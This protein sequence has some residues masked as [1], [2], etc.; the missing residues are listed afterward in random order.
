MLNVVKANFDN[1]NSLGVGRYIDLYQSTQCSPKYFAT[2]I[3]SMS[4][5]THFMTVNDCLILLRAKVIYNFM[6]YGLTRPIHKDGD[7]DVELATLK[8]LIDLGINLRLTEEECKYLN[9]KFSDMKELPMDAFYVYDCQELGSCVGKKYANIR[10]DRNAL[11][12]F[13]SNGYIDEFWYSKDKPIPTEVFCDTM[14]LVSFEQK[15]IGG[16]Y[17]VKGLDSVV[18]LLKGGNR[19][20]HTMLLFCEGKVIAFSANEVYG[21]NAVNCHNVTDHSFDKMRSFGSG[22]FVRAA[23]YLSELGVKRFNFGSCNND[24]GLEF[25]K[26]RH[27]PKYVISNRTFNLDKKITYDKFKLLL[28]KENK[29]QETFF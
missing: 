16:R 21:E 22:V 8:Y 7:R 26:K 15:R 12:K 6:C 20:I 4:F 23:E 25:F 11:R 14:Q 2:K 10:L 19:G 18:N 29:K 24:K 27:H 17:E 5:A 3:Y 9:I 1:Y 28:S 13:V